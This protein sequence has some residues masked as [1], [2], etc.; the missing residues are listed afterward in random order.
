MSPTVDVIVPVYGN[1]SL[2][3]QCLESLRGQTI[4]HRVILVDDKSPD[5]T[6]A[7]VAAEFP[8]VTVLAL[9][10][11]SGFA[12]AC[13]L[14][15]AAATAA[16]IVLVNNDVITSPSML[17][18]L[19]T[20]FDNPSVGSAVPVLFRPDGLID[21]FGIAAD[22][23][24]AGFLRLHGSQRDSIDGPLL[25]L[26]GPY[27]AVAAYRVEALREVGGL[28]EAIFMYGEELDLAL[29]LN[30]AGWKSAPTPLA[31]GIHLG[32]ATS[33]RGS[34]SQRERAGFGRGYLL[35]AYGILRGQHALRAVTIEV[36]V[37][38]GDLALSRDLASLRGRLAGW[39]AGAHTFTRN[40]AIADLD[41][42]IGF[43]DSLRLRIGSRT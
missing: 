43:I 39:R 4:E 25:T 36:I 10:V 37:C 20:P 16:V 22:V 35:R 26:L 40:R 28:D 7:R 30:A 34:A 23:T 6:L 9:G 21:A 29:R 31:T 13:N 41:R 32:G 12:A 17:E 42:S 24:L 11:N 38:A 2:T 3:A 18:H 15:I 5:D 1:W 33:G 8:D 27:G 19:V 14:G